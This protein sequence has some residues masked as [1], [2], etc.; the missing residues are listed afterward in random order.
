MVI[1]TDFSLLFPDDY[2][3]NISERLKL[4]TELNDL[5]N[6]EE[7]AAFEAK[8]IDRFGELPPQAEDLLNSVRIKWIATASGIEKITM[9]KGKLLGFFLADQQ[10]AFYQS[11]GFS[12]VLQF[13]QTHSNQVT[14][15][16]K[17]TRSGLRLLLSIPGITSVD[18]ALKVLAPLRRVIE[19]KE[20]AE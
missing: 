12:R 1:D 14:L 10:S 8:L 9:K 3:N 18:K 16:E 4:Y 15:K 20:S 5:K 11:P 17:K 6:E 7:L 19:V 2:I 13:V